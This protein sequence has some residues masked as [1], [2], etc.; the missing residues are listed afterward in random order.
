M[1]PSLLSLAAPE[2]VVLTSSSATSDGK[3]GIMV[4]GVFQSDECWQ[5]QIDGL[6]QERRNSFANTLELHLSCVRSHRN[7][8]I[9][10]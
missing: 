6:V 5:I 2:V 7:N 4:T 3:V 1:M 8:D 9:E 10:S